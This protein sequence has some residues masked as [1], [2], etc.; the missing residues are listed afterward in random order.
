M[1]SGSKAHSQEVVVVDQSDE[2][3]RGTEAWKESMK[4]TLRDTWAKLPGFADRKLMANGTY[5]KLG[6]H[7]RGVKIHTGP[8]QLRDSKPSRD[9]T[10]WCRDNK[11]YHPYSY[12]ES[13]NNKASPVQ[14]KSSGPPKLWI[15][16]TAKE[17]ETLKAKRARARA[18]SGQASTSDAASASPSASTSPTKAK[19][20]PPYVRPWDSEHN[21]MVSRMNHEVQVGV[22]EYF[23]KPIRKESEG[24]PKQR[25]EY[26]MNDRQLGWNDEPDRPGEARRTL[27]GNI[28]PYNRGGCKQQ[29]LPSYWR[30]I[31]DW[32]AYSTPE[33]QNLSL[34]GSRVA[35]MN[36]LEALADT[37]AAEATEFW[38]GW[39]ASQPGNKPECRR[40]D[41]TR[42][43][44]ALT[45]NQYIREHKDEGLEVDQLRGEWL[46]LERSRNGWDNRFNV[47]YS[48]GNS[49]LNFRCREYF[50]VPLGATGHRTP[51]PRT[52][53]PAAGSAKP[54]GKLKKAASAPQLD[55]ETWDPGAHTR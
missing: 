32:Q 55:D 10:Q 6:A 17:M 8:L 52:L 47:T 46:K 49:E 37:P 1:A 30:R 53:Q 15:P 12:F 7:A 27:Y 54:F 22:R 11:E 25:E 38:K 45:W 18:R 33:L 3:I 43:N 24:V 28:G 2:T 40:T 35:H 23:D 29:Q 21:V 31:K 44:R 36:L 4:L 5:S 41:P 20:Q 50:S 34:T 14:K 48:L 19:K 51:G 42:G 26:T 9:C 39:L 13:S 16:R